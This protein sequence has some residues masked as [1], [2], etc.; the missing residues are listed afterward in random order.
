M[1]GTQIKH[2]IE[3]HCECY[4]DSDVERVPGITAT[5]QLYIILRILATRKDEWN[6]K[7]A[8]LL[9]SEVQTYMGSN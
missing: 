7:K 5:K 9:I 1:E 2:G 6:E 3:G 4:A 8:F